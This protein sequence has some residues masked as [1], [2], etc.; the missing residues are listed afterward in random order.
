MSSNS[1]EIVQ[2]GEMAKY[3]VAIE[4]TEY[5]RQVRDDFRVI[6]HYG[7]EGGKVT[8]EKAEMGADNTGF[9]FTVDTSKMVG[10]VV[11]ECQWVVPDTDFAGGERVE[12]DRQIL[13][14]VAATACP[15]LLICPTCEESEKVTYT[16]TYEPDL[17]VEYFYLCDTNG[18]RFTT[19][20]EDGSHNYILV[21]RHRITDTE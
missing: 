6:L 16:R 17:N 7:M 9:Y 12:K 18:N 19:T 11:A 15:H 4:N 5:F 2:Q 13:M 10:R 8:V 14:F 3:Y 1:I 20:E 21:M